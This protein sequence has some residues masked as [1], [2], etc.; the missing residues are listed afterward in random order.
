MKEE[1]GQGGSGGQT[2]ASP[3]DLTDESRM[4]TAPILPP[5]YWGGC[6]ERPR[7]ATLDASCIWGGPA[8][9]GGTCCKASCP[10]R[11]SHTRHRKEQGIAAHHRRMPTRAG[12]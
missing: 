2:P 5:D 1:P 3:S 7:R 6:R 4:L 9:L 10:S 11:Q 8:V 12:Y